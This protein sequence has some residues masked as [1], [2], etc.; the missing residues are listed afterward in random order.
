MTI[1]PTSRLLTSG[2][3]YSDNARRTESLTGTSESS[4]ARVERFFLPFFFPRPPPSSAVPSSANFMIATWI[5][6]LK[7]PGRSRLRPVASRP[8][9][10]SW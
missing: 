4:P 6:A 9:P 3:T 5:S 2:I 7:K 8:S 10:A 1:A